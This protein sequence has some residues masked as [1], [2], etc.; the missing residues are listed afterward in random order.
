M[1]VTP[2]RGAGD[3]QGGDPAV[4]VDEVEASNYELLIDLC[5]RP[6][7]GALLSETSTVV[8]RRGMRNEQRPR[9]YIASS[10]LVLL[11]PLL[12]YSVTRDAFVLRGVGAYYGPVL[13][14]ERRRRRRRRQEAFNGV[15]RRAQ[16]A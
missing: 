13:R 6:R 2:P 11:T 7:H 10:W 15:D 16:T 14:P 8:R 1:G 5:K 4:V 3:A 9:R 12:R